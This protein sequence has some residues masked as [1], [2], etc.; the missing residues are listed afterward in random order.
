[1]HVATGVVG[2]HPGVGEHAG[3]GA[4]VID[5]GAHVIKLFD[6]IGAD[7]AG[8]IGIGVKHPFA[9]DHQ[10]DLGVGA[11]ARA[12]FFEI[13][14]TDLAAAVALHIGKPRNGVAVARRAALGGVDP[15]VDTVRREDGG[16]GVGVGGPGE[17]QHPAGLGLFQ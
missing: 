17:L 7:A 14:R 6:H 1:M 11:Y 9:T 15:I 13:Q 3:E 4:H 16:G 10:P 12:Q 5:A 8:G 2:H